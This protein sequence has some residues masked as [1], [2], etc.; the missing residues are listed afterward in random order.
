MKGIFITL[1]AILTLTYPLF[2]QNVN[3]RDTA[4]LNALI[5]QGVD[6]NKDSLISYAEAEA[7]TSLDI[8]EVTASASA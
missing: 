4:F 8:S 5:S 2:S 7:V 1:L 6:T 3:I